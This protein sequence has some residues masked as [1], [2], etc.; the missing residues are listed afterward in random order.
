LG[1]CAQLTV[2]YFQPKCLLCASTKPVECNDFCSA[3]KSK[4]V[5]ERNPSC[6]DR[7]TGLERR[8][9]NFVVKRSKM[10]NKMCQKSETT[11]PRGDL[12]NEQIGFLL[13]FFFTLVRGGSGLRI[14]TKKQA[15]FSR[16]TLE[17]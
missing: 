6:L 8:Q 1:F 13:P 11:I 4:T 17:T 12:K 7:V 14:T 3:F 2:V 5:A 15:P 10:D 9:G 16:P